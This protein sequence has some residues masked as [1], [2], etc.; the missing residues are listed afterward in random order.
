MLTS[1]RQIVRKKKKKANSES[2][3]HFDPNLS[4]D[5]GPVVEK[6][7]LNDEQGADSESETSFCST[8][9]SNDPNAVVLHP[10]ALTHIQSK[11]KAQISRKKSA[12]DAIAKLKSNINL[13]RS[14]KK[15]NTGK[16]TCLP[17]RVARS[18]CVTNSVFRNVQEL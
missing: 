7:K 12:D 18:D 11:L 8:G 17:R 10:D 2:D 13:A 14:S 5:E 16:Y 4:G 15:M 1:I 9:M 6:R 3:L